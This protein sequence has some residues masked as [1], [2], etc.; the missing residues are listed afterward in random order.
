[1]PNICGGLNFSHTTFCILLNFSRIVNIKSVKKY[2]ILVKINI[3][4]LILN[5]KE[6]FGVKEL[7]TILRANIKEHLIELRVEHGLS[8]VEVA[9]I[10]GKTRTAV[11]SWEQGL[12]LPDLA[13]LYRLSK[14]YNKTMEYFFENTTPPEG[15]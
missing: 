11:A 3:F 15:N 7:D 5:S 4:V 14:Y 2:K 8:Q 1:M 6:V 13:T 9:N 12:S 10:T